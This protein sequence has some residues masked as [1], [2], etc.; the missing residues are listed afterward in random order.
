MGALAEIAQQFS[1]DTMVTKIEAEYYA[2]VT[3]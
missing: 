1:V 3:A 2:L